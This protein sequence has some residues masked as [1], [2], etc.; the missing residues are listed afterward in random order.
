M[1]QSRMLASTTTAIAA[2]ALSVVLG[3]VGALAAATNRTQASERLQNIAGIWV[4]N[5]DL[6]DDPRPQLAGRERDDS[7]RP[8]LGGGFGGRRRGPGGGFGG[9]PG[10]GG[11]RGGFGGGGDRPDPT[12]LARMRQGMQ[13]A[14]R[15]L[16]T[17]P[18]RMTIGGT[19]DEIGVTYAN[20]RLMR[21]IPDDREHAGIAGTNMRVTRKTQWTD[22]VLVTEVELESRIAFTVEQSYEALVDDAAGRQL[23]VT[24]RFSGDNVEDDQVFRRVYDAQ[25]Q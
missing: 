8:G 19:D 15:E 24:S 3:G 17:A 21:L 22:G 18:R 2:I 5:T 23:I 11:D 16:T 10:F 25:A 7:D 12:D 1:S 6:S 14:I 4:L 9:R 20:G 13:E